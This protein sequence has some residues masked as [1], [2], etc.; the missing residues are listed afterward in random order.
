MAFTFKSNY[1]NTA[2]VMRTLQRLWAP[3][4]EASLILKGFNALAVASYTIAAPVAYDWI[5][6]GIRVIT[7]TQTGTVTTG[8]TFKLEEVNAAGTVIQTLFAA[9]TLS[10]SSV[11]DFVQS[12]T[13]AQTLVIQAGNSIKGSVTVVEIGASVQTFDVMLTGQIV[14][15]NAA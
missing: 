11:V 13:P 7:K 15:L 10:T 9:A 3:P 14:G 2:L 6:T 1:L 8:V 4:A 12:L 5:V